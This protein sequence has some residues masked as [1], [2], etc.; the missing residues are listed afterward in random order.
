MKG[1]LTYIIILSFILFGIKETVIVSFYEVNKEYI[2]KI[3]CINKEKP[4]LKC[5]G[6]CH[7]KKMIKKSEKKE[8]ESFPEGT[9]E[10][11]VLTFV[12]SD[13]NQNF[14]T[15]NKLKELNKTIYSEHLHGVLSFAD[16]FHP[17]QV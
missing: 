4:E 3:Y 1:L 12:K 17:P 16:I 8:Q 7:M 14:S 9:L 11:K 15:I 5:D 13:F 10:L 2:T 6:K